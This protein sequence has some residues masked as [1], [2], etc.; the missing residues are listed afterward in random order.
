MRFGLFTYGGGWSIV[1]QMDQLYVQ[2][3]KIITSEELLDLVSV[4]KSIPGTMIANVAM[5]F[6]YRTAGLFGGVI[7][8][9]G[10]CFPP[11][12]VLVLISFFYEAFRDNYWVSAAMQGM[13]A[14][15][16]PIIASVAVNLLK[17]SL[18]YPPCVVIIGISTLIYLFADI[19]PVL[20]VVFGAVAGLLMGEYYERK[21][22]K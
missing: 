17:G 5:L 20:L 15:V 6:G 2:K 16:V 3:K 13:Q 7:C 19:H 9:F 22:R 8:V 1:A 18:K 4:A 21:E 14:A 11:M 10:M 12:A